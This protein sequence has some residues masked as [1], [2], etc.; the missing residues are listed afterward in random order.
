M[1]RPSS[2]FVAPAGA[3]AL[4]GSRPACRLVLG[5]AWDERFDPAVL[6]PDRPEFDP[7]DPQSLDFLLLGELCPEPP[8]CLLLVHSVL[9][10]SNNQWLYIALHAVSIQ[11]LYR[12]EKRLKTAQ[13]ALRMKPELKAAAEKAAEADHRSLTSLVE[14]LLTEYCR[15]KGFLK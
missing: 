7:P 10:A 8:A 3:A 2:V 6:R 13:I 14:K 9:L 15:K 11:W 1:V 5:S 12:M 4:S